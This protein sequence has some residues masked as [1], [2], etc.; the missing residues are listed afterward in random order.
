MVYDYIKFDGESYCNVYVDKT[1]AH[2]VL[3]FTK[4]ISVNFKLD[5]KCNEWKFNGAWMIG[6][7][8]REW[9]ANE[10]DDFISEFPDLYDEIIKRLYSK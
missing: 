8:E 7:S 6:V 4:E 3:R 9:K 10:G 5:N 2:G 1:T